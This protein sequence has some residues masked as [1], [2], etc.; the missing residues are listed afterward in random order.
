MFS[1]HRCT[2]RHPVVTAACVLVPLALFSIASSNFLQALLYGRPSLDFH[3]LGQRFAPAVG[4]ASSNQSSFS[5]RFHCDVDGL[6][7]GSRSFPPFL[8]SEAY[9]DFPLSLEDAA[10]QRYRKGTM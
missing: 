8:T 5:S 6:V 9:P 2:L 3:Y 1:V 7:S 4:A 10:L